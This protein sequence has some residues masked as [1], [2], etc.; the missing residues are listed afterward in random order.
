MALETQKDGGDDLLT[1]QVSGKLSKED[2]ERFVPELKN[3]IKEHGKIQILFDM[4]DFHG[5]EL[6]AMWADLKFG[7][8]HFADIKKLAMV[9]DKKWE[10]WMAKFC[11]P[12]TRA[13][14][15]YGQSEIEKASDCE[16]N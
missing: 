5:W 4:N 16:G 13:K 3:M 10:E 2:Y 11:K 8:K 7:T 6:G 9:G 1:V 12:F 15:E 14:I